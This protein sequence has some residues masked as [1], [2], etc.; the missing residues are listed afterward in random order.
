MEKQEYVKPEIK[1]V[2]LNDEIVLSSVVCAT[3]GGDTCSGNTCPS[4][5]CSGYTCS[6]V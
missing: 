6:G 2:F 1:I 4:Y 5:T 3:D